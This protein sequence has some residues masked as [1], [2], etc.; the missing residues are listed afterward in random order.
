MDDLGIKAAR[1]A[2]VQARYDELMHEGKHG[3]YETMSRVV[4]EEVE[5]T[6]EPL[7]EAALPFAQHDW[8]DAELED[9]SCKLTK[10]SGSITVGHWRALRAALGL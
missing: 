5:R 10:H 7:R 8:Y 2:R 1:N 6:V 9:D 3:H 4:R